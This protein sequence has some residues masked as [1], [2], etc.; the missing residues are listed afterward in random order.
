MNEFRNNGCDDEV[1]CFNCGSS[2]VEKA[3]QRQVFQYGN[4]DNAVELTAEVPV[5]TCKNCAY[6]F[7]SAEA[8]DAR[9]EAVCRHLGVLPPREIISIREYAGLSQAQFAKCSRIGIASLKR[10]E[11]GVVIQNAANDELI[12]LMTF[13]EN[14][15]RLKQ[16]NHLEP[17]GSSVVAQTQASQS[18]HRGT[19]RFRGRCIAPEG[20]LLERSKQWTLIQ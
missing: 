16:R 14:I 4:G 5:F 6:Q 1:V 15:E 9:H 13:P 11:T 2:D 7:A 12:Y 10:W 20:I 8:D 3:L 17:I 19:S 18:H